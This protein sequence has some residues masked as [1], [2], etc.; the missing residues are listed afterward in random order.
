MSLFF[1]FCSVVKTLGTVA[2][3]TTNDWDNSIFGMVTF[4]KN[5]YKET[6][7]RKSIKANSKKN[8]R[9]EK[10]EEIKMLNNQIKQLN[11]DKQILTNEKEKAKKEFKREIK[12]LNEDKQKTIDFNN[13]FNANLKISGFETGNEMERGR[14]LK[15][16]GIPPELLFDKGS[17]T[18]KSCVLTDLNLP[19]SLNFMNTLHGKK[20]N[21][22]ALDINCSI[23]IVE[24]K[25]PSSPNS[26]S[27]IPLQISEEFE[28]DE[29]T[30]LLNGDLQK[31]MNVKETEKKKEQFS[32]LETTWLEIQQK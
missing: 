28:D 9:R 17:F 15:D 25:I 22:N 26:P 27:I 11:E 4:L 31:T 13:R 6:N 21:D 7:R 24:S 23:Y 8:F 3:Q 19:E 30:Q 32:L 12:H 18:D 2:Y 10:E 16:V 5:R 20:Y 29:N 1:S 14:F